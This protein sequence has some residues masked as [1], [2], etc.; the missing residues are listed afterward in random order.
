MELRSCQGRTG[1]SDVIIEEFINFTSEITLLTVT[2]KNGETLF[3]P[4]IGHR[5]ERGDYQESWQPSFIL[6]AQL[7]KRRILRK[8]DRRADGSRN[9][10]RE[11][12]PDRNRRLFFRTLPRPH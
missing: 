10:G 7:L 1:D 4:P 9:L 3:C 6:P 8:S 5:Q 11:F 12:F 2:Q